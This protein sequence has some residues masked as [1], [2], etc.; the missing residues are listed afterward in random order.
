MTGL[1]LVLEPSLEFSNEVVQVREIHSLSV[2]LLNIFGWIV[3][4]VN[5]CFDATWSRYGNFVFLAEN[6]N[7]FINGRKSFFLLSS[8]LVKN[9]SQFL[10]KLIC[11][12][13]E[14]QI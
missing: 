5:L 6:D 13:K 7:F 4:S 2:I 1:L 3:R 14:I 11:S 10:K 9:F 12:G 8:S